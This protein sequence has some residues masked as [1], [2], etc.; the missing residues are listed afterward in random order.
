MIITLIFLCKWLQTGM[1]LGPTVLGRFFP[2]ISQVLFPQQ[3]IEILSTLTRFGYLFFMFLIGVRMDINL[4]TKSGKREWTIGSMV[5]VF[6]LVITV[7]VAKYISTTVDKMDKPSQQW[8]ALF[9]GCLMLT[10]FPVVACL[11]MHLKIINSELGHLV[12][13]S[14]LISDLMSVLIINTDYYA[15][16]VQLAS[17]RVGNKSTFFIIALILFVITILRQL[18]YWII[19]RTPE[20]KSVKDAYI[21]FLMI[22]L[23][24]VAIA[25]DSVG[26]QY[27]YGPFILGLTVPTG[28]PLAST[29]I[30][31]LDTVVSGWILPLTSTYCGYKS[32]LW[33]LEMRPPAFIV[34]VLTFGFM[35]KISC[36]FV[37]AI[38]FK[39]PCKDATALALMLTAKGI[40]ELGTFATNA[41]RQVLAIIPF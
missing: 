16:I 30:Q 34:F 38:C 8:V 23:F 19:R 2:K 24:L 12:L 5:I 3:S 35:L 27:M 41:D 21:F 9:T 15:Q 11:L 6:P 25:G 36:A 10:S 40:I 14:A 32:N 37:P 39:M 17:L 22:A 20:G 7:N 13:S 31:K 33:D 29:L 28:Q 26:L 18:I 1:I 4:I